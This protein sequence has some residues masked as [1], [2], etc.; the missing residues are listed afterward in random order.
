MNPSLPLLG[1]S[2]WFWRDTNGFLLRLARAQGDVARF[3][4]GRRDAF[5]LSHPDHVRRVLVDDAAEFR[6]GD[7]MRRARRL[8]GDGLLTSEGE[9]HRTH[10]RAMQPAFARPK[11]ATYA[12]VVPDLAAAATADWSDGRVVDVAA[13]MDRLTLA[14]VVRTLLGADPSPLEPDLRVI[15]ARGP[16]L[17][18]P[19]A[20]FLERLRIPPFA[21]AGRAAGRLRQAMSHHVSAPPPMNEPDHAMTMF[22]AGHDTTAAAL[23]WAWYLLATHP[24]V[25]ARL[26]QELDGVLGNR[27]PEPDDSS[28]LSYTSMVFEETLRLFP[29][30]GRIGRRPLRDYTIDGHRIPAG[31]PV[32]LSPFVTQRDPRWW[33][34]PHAFAPERWTAAATASRPRFASFPFGAGPRS[35][36]GGAM[37]RLIGVLVIATIARRW[38]LHPIAR[39]APRIRPILTLK[40]AGGLR[41]RAVSA[42]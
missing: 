7:L 23:T 21:A 8:L 32:F 1:H 14:I 26:R 17:A 3:R 34:D 30:I 37:A 13:V 9:V 4:L 6:K 33:P 16:L 42:A 18:L 10:R 19:C 40:P 22:L 35:C 41:L 20:A 2:P 31:S 12:A 27:C 24:D 36:I 39:G 15:S 25:A 29:P 38:S 11:L 5:L 28:K